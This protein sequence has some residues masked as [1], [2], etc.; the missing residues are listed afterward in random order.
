MH[1][2][3][4]DPRMGIW[5]FKA[6]AKVAL[7]VPIALMACVALSCAWWVMCSLV[8]SALQ[9]T[10][11]LRL[12]EIPHRYITFGQIVLMALVVAYVLR[13][14]AKEIRSIFQEKS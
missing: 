8:L 1:T 5:T 10:G 6:I 2:A 14:V 13:G 11:L 3:R 7:M 9:A 12:S 4:H